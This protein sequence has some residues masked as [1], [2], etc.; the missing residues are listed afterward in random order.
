M[1]LIGGATKVASAETVK[2]LN[3]SKQNKISY[4][5]S[6]PTTLEEGEIYLQIL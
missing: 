4:G 5:T 2:S 6:I 3:N 1:I